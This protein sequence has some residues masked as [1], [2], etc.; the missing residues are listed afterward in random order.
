MKK[1]EL[2]VGPRDTEDSGRGPGTDNQN[3]G[4]VVDKH[5][6]GSDPPGN[7]AD[8]VD[9]QLTSLCLD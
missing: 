8:G 5:V 9:K 2:V 4:D 3:V 7:W 6:W 1:V